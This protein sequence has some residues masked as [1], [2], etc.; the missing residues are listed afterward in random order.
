MGNG[1]K[2]RK[3]QTAPG[4]ASK[5]DK[6]RLRRGKPSKARIGIEGVDE[7]PPEPYVPTPPIPRGDLGIV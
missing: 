4:S 1:W 2:R 7:L 5:K 6:L 3:G